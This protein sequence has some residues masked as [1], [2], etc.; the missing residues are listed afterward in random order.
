MQLL[1]VTHLVGKTTVDTKIIKDF[2]V[3]SFIAGAGD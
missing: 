3:Y 1:H 2:S